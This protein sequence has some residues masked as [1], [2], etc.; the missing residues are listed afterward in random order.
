MKR[1]LYSGFK[2]SHH[3]NFAEHDKIADDF[4]KVFGNDLPLSKYLNK[5]I[6]HQSFSNY[7]I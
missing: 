2:F 7:I 6:N 4:P 1:V 3:S 5:K